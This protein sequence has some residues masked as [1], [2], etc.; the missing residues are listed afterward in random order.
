MVILLSIIAIVLV[1]QIDIL[2]ETMNDLMAKGGDPQAL[3]QKLAVVAVVGMLAGVGG[4]IFIRRSNHPVAIKV[5]NLLSGLIDGVMSIL[6]MEKKWQFIAH[7]AFIWV[8]YLAMFWV[9]FYALPETSNVSAAGVLASF[10]VG[11]L[12][13]VLVQGGIGVYPWGVSLVLVAYGV[14][15]T[16]GVTLG[17]IIWTAQTMMI[18]FWGAVSL[19]GLPMVNSSTVSKAS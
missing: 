19:I 10:V 11:G 15:E 14:P 8:M 17:W 16:A 6:K 18:L 7:T 12:S 13:I 5:K 4:L 1:L 3:L 2:R 9:V